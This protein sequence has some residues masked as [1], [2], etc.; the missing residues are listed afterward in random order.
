M[1]GHDLPSSLEHDNAYLV[2]KMFTLLMY[3]LS[4]FNEAIICVTQI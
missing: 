4:I 2:Y 3:V 1:K